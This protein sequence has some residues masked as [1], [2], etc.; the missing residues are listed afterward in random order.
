MK[1]LNYI[2]FDLS[3]AR[4]LDYYTEVIYKTD[5]MNGSVIIRSIGGE[6]G[7]RRYDNLA[8]M[9]SETGKVTPLLV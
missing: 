9:I 7:R 1:R 5:Y 2:S 6:G 8:S 3:F 4:G